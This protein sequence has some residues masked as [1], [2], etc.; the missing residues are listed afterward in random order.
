MGREIIISLINNNLKQIYDFLKLYHIK[1]AFKKRSKLGIVPTGG[2]YP[3]P[4]LLTGLLKNTQ[5]ALKGIINT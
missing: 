4:N 5:N 1:K 3:D 2:V